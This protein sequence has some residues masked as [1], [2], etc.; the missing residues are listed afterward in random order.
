MLDMNGLRTGPV[1][2]RVKVLLQL[3]AGADPACPSPLDRKDLPSLKEMSQLMD[4]TRETICRELKAL[5][6]RIPP[7]GPSSGINRLGSCALAT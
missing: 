4:I 2:S 5:F 1:S 6:A 7:M 3:L